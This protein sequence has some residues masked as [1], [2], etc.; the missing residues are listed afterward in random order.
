MGGFFDANGTITINHT[1]NQLSI[2]I[3]Q[4]TEELLL[5]L[6]ELYGGN[7]YID[8]SSNTFK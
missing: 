7:I 8:R 3:G 4:K 5:P 6:K 2:S 1:T